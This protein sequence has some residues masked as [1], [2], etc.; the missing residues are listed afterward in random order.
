MT[1][2]DRHAL[3][4]ALVWLHQWTTS[5]AAR[6]ALD[7]AIDC[8]RLGGSVCEDIEDAYTDRHVVRVYNREPRLLRARLALY[9]RAVLRAE[10]RDFGRECRVC[11]LCGAKNECREHGQWT[12]YYVHNQRVGYTLAPERAG[13]TRRIAPLWQQAPATGTRRAR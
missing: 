5:R 6:D 3:E 7:F 9:I 4:L 1:R 8:I 2:L 11:L 10:A 13:T 12:G